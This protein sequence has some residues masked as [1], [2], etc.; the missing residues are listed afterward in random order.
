M[1]HL[2]FSGDGHKLVS[3]GM[4]RCFSIQV[5][6]WKQGRSIAFRN[7]GFAP[8]FAIK[9]NPF[10]DN[11]FITCGY[12]HLCEWKID[13][14]HL[15][16]VKHVSVYGRPGESNPLEKNIL[17]DPE[18]T[19]APGNLGHVQQKNILMSMDFISYRLGHSVQS[20]LIIGNNF[21][22][23][24]TYCSSKYFVLNE[25]A[26][27]RSPINVVKVTNTLSLDMRQV[28][29]VTG[30]EDG[31][32]KIWDAS[33]QLKQVVDLKASPAV[34]IKDLKN[35]KSYG[36]QSID[37]FPCDKQ[38]VSSTAA[39]K[40]LTGLRSG[41]VIEVLLDLNRNFRDAEEIMESKAMDDD[42]K[43]QELEKLKYAR[44]VDRQRYHVKFNSVFS[45]HSS[46]Q[47][48]HKQKKIITCLY[49]MFGILA[50]VGNDETL[51]VWD[52]AKNVVLTSKNLGTQATCLDFSPD[53]K[54]LAVGLANGVFL[55]L[56]SKIE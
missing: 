21:G 40:V 52:I 24:C 10:D 38:S 27:P 32:L 14:L 46:L 51:M 23:I 29:V 33:I 19:E 7:T 34:A 8:I 36:I 2:V 45:G 6:L 31:L 12:Q 4:D 48:S 39:I 1:L 37:V 26:H 43:Q 5:F 13:G 15:T 16:V 35:I 53:G 22:D 42:Q 3:I 18:T 55:L 50:S 28:N 44:E 54:F 20:D 49:P 17:V 41:D 25:Q 11:V 56:D 47:L 30:G 9:F